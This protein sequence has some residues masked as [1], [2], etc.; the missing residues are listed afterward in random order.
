MIEGGWKGRRPGGGAIIIML[1]ELKE[2]SLVVTKWRAETRGGD[3]G[4]GGPAATE[5]TDEDDDDD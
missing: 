2:L 3:G 1:N 5:G 4:G